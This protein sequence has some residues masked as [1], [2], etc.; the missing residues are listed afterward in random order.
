LDAFDEA[1]IG[2]DPDGVVDRLTRDGTDLG[3]RDFG[4]VLHRAVRSIGH[5]L[6]DCQTLS[7]DLDTV[8]A[9]KISWSDG[10]LQGRD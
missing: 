8:S 4:D 3:P 1:P 2:Q 9:K 5:R 10:R 7:R 6:H